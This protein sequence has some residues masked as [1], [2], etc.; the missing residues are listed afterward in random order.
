MASTKSHFPVK[1][2][3]A[4]ISVHQAFEDWANPTIRI[5]CDGQE[6]TLVVD[7]KDQRVDIEIVKQTP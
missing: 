5:E 7:K 1:V 3:S 2:G 6:V 4:K